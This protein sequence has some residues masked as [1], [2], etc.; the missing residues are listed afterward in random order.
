MSETALALPRKIVW[1]RPTL[2]QRSG[3]IAFLV[4]L[5]VVGILIIISPHH[6]SYF[7]LSTISASATTLAL[8]GIGETIVVLA[9]DSI[10]RPAPSSRLSTSCWSPS[11][12]RLISGRHLHDSGGGNRHRHR[13]G[14][15]RHQRRARELPSPSIH[16]RHLGDDVRCP[17]RWSSDPKYPGGTSRTISPIYWSAT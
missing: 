2:L 11:L 5:V 17:G 16:H 15:R 13:H 9:G 1:L 4:F 6:L 7:D 12:A 10:F 14:D 8:A 3:A